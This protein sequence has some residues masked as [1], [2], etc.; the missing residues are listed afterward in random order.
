VRAPRLVRLPPPALR[1]AAGSSTPLPQGA[2]AASAQLPDRIQPPEGLPR[3]PGLEIATAT[4]PENVANGAVRGDFV[5]IFGMDGAFGFAWG[6][7]SGCAAAVGPLVTACKALVRATLLSHPAV[8]ATAHRL[9]RAFYPIL[10]DGRSLAL[11]FGLYE[12][13]ERRL[14]VCNCGSWPAILMSEARTSLVGRTGP[15]LGDYDNWRYPPTAITL[16][17]GAVLVGCT[18]GVPEAAGVGIASEA[19]LPELLARLRSLP[20][21]AAAI[22]RPESDGHRRLERRT[23]T[24]LVLRA[25]A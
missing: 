9:S 19:R 3:I 23:G 11:T 6:S 20:A 15:L 7:L 22:L 10:S 4:Y 1:E 21:F 2:R 24:V 14:V 17:P 25:V 13:E 12:P 8:G 16:A 5:D 18:T